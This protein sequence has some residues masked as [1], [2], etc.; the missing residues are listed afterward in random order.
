MEFGPS[1]RVTESS[2]LTG[3][4]GNDFHDSLEWQ[5]CLGQLPPWKAPGEKKEE[6]NKMNE[7]FSV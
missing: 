3:A 7:N 6:F 2:N 5:K 1:L 4:L